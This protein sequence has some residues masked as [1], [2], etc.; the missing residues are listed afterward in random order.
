MTEEI[1]RNV[2]ELQHIKVGLAHVHSKC[3]ISFSFKFLLLYFFLI[4]IYDYFTKV[5]CNIRKSTELVVENKGNIPQ[6]E[7]I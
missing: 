7:F 6:A 2:P 1:V 5:L 4:L 3:I